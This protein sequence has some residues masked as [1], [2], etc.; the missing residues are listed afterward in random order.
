[1][2]VFKQVGPPFPVTAVKLGDHPPPMLILAE[3]L[4]VNMCNGIKASVF[5]RSNPVQIEMLLEPGQ[6]HL[7]G[8]SDKEGLAVLAALLKRFPK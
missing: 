5:V 7:K 3:Y 8:L 2:L 6:L 1:M 4:N